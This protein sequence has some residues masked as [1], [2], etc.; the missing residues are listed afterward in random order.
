[1]VSDPLEKNIITTDFYFLDNMKCKLCR[2]EKELLTKSHIIPNFMYKEFFD[3]N[4]TALMVSGNNFSNVQNKQTGEYESNILCKTCDNEKIGKFE[5]YAKT[6][7]YGGNNIRRVNIPNCINE[8]NKNGIE[9]T[10]CQGINYKKFKLFL[11]SVLWRSSISS[12]PFFSEVS[13]GEKH[14]ENIRK[15]IL[16]EEPGNIDDYPCVMTK[17]NK[18]NK[19]LSFITNPKK[20]KDTLGTRYSFFIG[21]IWYFYCVSKASIPRWFSECTLNKKNEMRIIHMGEEDENFFLE[22]QLGI[23]F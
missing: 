18:Y 9:F 6:V 5:N 13:L 16:Y 14:S 21:G 1:M 19:K 8:K 12:R 17:Y 23:K 2:Q 3:E 4:H 22:K 20:F 10:Y 15:M 11:L 7:L